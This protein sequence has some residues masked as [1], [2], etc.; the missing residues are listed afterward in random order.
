MHIACQWVY[1]LY[2]CWAHVVYAHNDPPGEYTVCV[3]NLTQVALDTHV[4]TCTLQPWSNN[5][6]R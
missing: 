5:E 1:V 4:D 3:Y 2:L 6:P